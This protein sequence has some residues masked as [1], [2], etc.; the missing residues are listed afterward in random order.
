MHLKTFFNL[1]LLVLIT[2]FHLPLR[3]SNPSRLNPTA[4]IFV[5]SFSSY[6][7]PSSSSETV[8]PCPPALRYA[9]PTFAHP[10][11]THS[12]YVTQETIQLMEEAMHSSTSAQEKAALAEKIKFLR[13]FIEDMKKKHPIAYDG[14]LPAGHKGYLVPL[15]PPLPCKKTSSPQTLTTPH[16]PTEPLSKFEKKQKAEKY[17]LEK[18][19]QKKLAAAQK[20]KEKQDQAALEEKQYASVQTAYREKEY[21]TALSALAHCDPTTEQFVNNVFFITEC[22][23][24]TRAEGDFHHLHTTIEKLIA[25]VNPFLS[26]QKK[27]TL[28]LYLSAQASSEKRRT[29]LEQAAALK[30]PIAEVQLLAYK[31]KEYLQEKH[32][33]KCSAEEPCIHKQGARFLSSHADNDTLKTVLATY[34]LSLFSIFSGCPNIEIQFPLEQLYDTAQKNLDPKDYAIMTNVHPRPSARTVKYEHPKRGAA[35]D[36][37]SSYPPGMI[38]LNALI[39]TALQTDPSSVSVF[40]ITPSRA[41]QPS[42][43]Y[44]DLFVRYFETLEEVYKEFEEKMQEASPIQR[45]LQRTLLAREIE[46]RH[47][48]LRTLFAMVT[49]TEE[50]KLFTTALGHFKDKKSYA[51]IA[52]MLDSFLQ[53]SSKDIKQ[54]WHEREGIPTSFSHSEAS[55]SKEGAASVTTIFLPDTRDYSSP[56]TNKFL[57]PLAKIVKVSL[58]KKATLGAIFSIMTTLQRPEAHYFMY[59]LGTRTPH[60][61]GELQKM[62]ETTSEDT[63]DPPLKQLLLAGFK[64]LRN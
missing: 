29:Y 63:F 59:A 41:L 26:I 55:P 51:G 43:I 14:T 19:Q 44:P 47:G 22:V 42:D 52:K 27:S 13:E 39:D 23:I 8:F 24:H 16:L 3:P 60:L 15:L 56:H 34:L 10:E 48:H 33:E 21:E 7:L 5:P 18:A 35:D 37:T 36:D 38:D 1:T 31:T 25:T 6:S 32:S 64:T 53:E 54:L 2:F 62:V 45:K 49:N 12:T 40:R 46:K 50:A 30:N 57:I 28:L 17:R 11:T 61:L 20:L 58:N 9:P 4:P